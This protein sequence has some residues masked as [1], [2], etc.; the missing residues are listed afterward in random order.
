MAD[1]QNIRQIKAMK[2][3]EKIGILKISP[4]KKGVPP[5][6]FYKVDIELYNEIIEELNRED[7]NKITGDDD[8][9]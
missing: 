8:S 1:Y 4:K 2:K 6:T 3:L 5:K 9:A 7:R